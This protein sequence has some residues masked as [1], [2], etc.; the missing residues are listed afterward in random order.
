MLRR[1]FDL[2]PRVFG[3]DDDEHTKLENAI[4]AALGDLERVIAA[5]GRDGL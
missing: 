1:F 4:T 3:L 5:Q 2:T